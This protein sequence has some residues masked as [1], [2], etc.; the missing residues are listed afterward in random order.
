MKA[1]VV[2]IFGAF[3]K[4]RLENQTN[5]II[6]AKI[7]GKL[8]LRD[9]KISYFEPQER[10][11]LTIGDIVEIYHDNEQNDKEVYISEI[12]PRRNSLRRSTAYQKQTLGANLDGVIIISSLDLPSFNEGLMVR[13]L[14]ESVL[15]QIKPILILNKMDLMHKNVEKQ[16]QYTRPVTIMKYFKET[17][18]NVFFETFA[19]GI[20]TEL[21]KSVKKGRFIAFG[22]SGVGKSTFINQMLGTKIQAVDDQD[23]TVKGRHVTSNPALYRAN[24]NFELIDVPGVRE[25]GLMHRLATEISGG[26]PE[27]KKHECRYGNCQHLDEPDCGV[28]NAL[29]NKEYPEFRYQQYLSIMES[30]TET[31]KP[32]R[33]D[34]RNIK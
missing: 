27:F 34:F 5:Q 21:R 29:H 16:E 25:F 19:T 24:K 31:R 23:I 4:V 3:Y 30:M 15:S 33:G 6:L 13:I 18:L 17:G 20:G 2:G 26:F 11:P 22:E 14:V 32:R 7:R 12:Y 10:H 8:R 9:K 1:T 28:K